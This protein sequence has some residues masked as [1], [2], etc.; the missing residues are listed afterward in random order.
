MGFIKKFFG[1]ILFLALLLAGIGFILP[2]H[3]NV[4][5]SI[6]I[7]SP[8]ENVFSKVSDFR[9]FNKWSPWAKKDPQTQYTFSEKTSGVGASMQW[10]SKHPY[11]GTGSQT[12]TA[13][14]PNKRVEIKLHFDDQGDAFAYYELIPDVTN[15][16]ITWGFESKFGYN[17]IERYMGLMFDKWIGEEYEQG[18]TDLKNLLEN[19]PIKQS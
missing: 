1:F 11:V 7:S 2:D 16:K 9:E 15:T 8:I 3:S 10:Q 18:L 5:R 17:L 13:V 19:P 4:E 12:I 6:T 14:E